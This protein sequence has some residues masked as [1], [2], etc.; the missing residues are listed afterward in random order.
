M[1]EYTV[2]ASTIVLAAAIGL[3]GYLFFRKWQAREVA[4]ANEGAMLR[5]LIDNLPDLIYVKDIDGRFLLANVAVARIMGAKA[6][7]DLLGK[8]DFDFHPK[9]L[10][11][12]YHEDEQAVI[13]SGNPLLAREEECRHPAGHLVL[14]ETT[15]IP[16]RDQ[17]GRVIGLVGIGRDVTLRVARHGRW[18]LRC[19]NLGK[20]S[21]RCSAARVIGASPFRA[22]PATCFCW[23]KASMS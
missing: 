4:A 7:S 23:R 11:T 10:A 9:D 8:N 13:R 3:A 5:T 16:L 2:Y 12:L 19:A 15:K 21:R 22:R 1:T 20:S 17:A 18:M 14:L 6:P